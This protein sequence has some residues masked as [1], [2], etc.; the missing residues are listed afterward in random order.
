MERRLGLRRVTG[1]RFHPPDELSR[2][3]ADRSPHGHTRPQGVRIAAVFS[4]GTDEVAS[5]PVPGGWQ[6]VQVNG[7]GVVVVVD[8]DIRPA[9]FVQIDDRHSAAVPNVI[10]PG[11]APDVVE[12]SVPEVEEEQ[13][14]LGAIP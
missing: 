1:A 11:G 14:P 6:P 3:P 4:C 13:L 7:R 12:F 2:P 9:V 10:A 8:D 5:E